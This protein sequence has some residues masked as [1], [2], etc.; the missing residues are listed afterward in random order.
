MDISAQMRAIAVA[1][2]AASR[3]L[4][5]AEG[6]TRQQA[7]LNLADL[8]GKSAAAIKTANAKDIA[9]AEARGLD[10]ARLDR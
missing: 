8:L 5:A 10:K 6:C 3:K 2:R 9:A 4:S 1:A 7:L